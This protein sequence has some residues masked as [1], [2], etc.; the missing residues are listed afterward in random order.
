MP[1]EEYYIRGVEET[2]ARGPFTVDQLVTLGEVGQIDLE[3]LYY[4]ATTEQW[5]A[6]GSNEAL[7]AAVF[8]SKKK[9]TIRAKE[10]IAT[11]NV[12]QEDHKPIT[13]EQMLAAAEGHT[14]DTKDR[15]NLVEVQNNSARIGM[16]SALVMFLL[17][18]A[19]L[20]L[21][22]ADILLTVNVAKIVVQPFIYLGL[23]DVAC[24]V[25]LTLGM[26]AVYPFIRFRAMLGIGFLGLF[27][28]LQGHPLVALAVTAGSVGMYLS[29]VFLTYAPISAA[30]VLGLAGIGGFAYFQLLR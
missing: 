29:T 4:E 20:L 9:L 15:R 3:T 11:L 25:L 17:S 16:Y 24:L 2:E 21:P 10:N 30:A 1:S 8:P 14:E 18:A 27:F 13:V 5:A 12:A 19:A 6:F 7:K 26:A 28:L 23:I 22:Y